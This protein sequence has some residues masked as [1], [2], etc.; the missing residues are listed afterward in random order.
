[1]IYLDNNATRAIDPLVLK[2]MMPYFTTH[3]GNP[4]SL[5]RL[6][7]EAERA[8]KQSRE[9]IAEELRVKPNEVVFTSGATESINWALRA[10]AKI[11]KR[12]GKHIITTAIEHSAVL[13]T[14]NA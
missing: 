5:H 8:I 6:G 4:S 2:E 3:F 12:K 7:L 10:G 13:A 14:C 1:M 11:N 9:R